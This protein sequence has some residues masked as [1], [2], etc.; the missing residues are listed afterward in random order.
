[1]DRN[2]PVHQL[3]C[4]ADRTE[5]DRALADRFAQVVHLGLLVDDAGGEED[6][7][8]VHR[9]TARGGEESARVR[10][11][12]IDQPARHRHP[13]ALGLGAQTRK[14]LVARDALRKAGVVV[15]EWDVRGAAR[16]VVHQRDA[17]PETREVDRRGESR[18]SRADD[19]AIDLALHSGSF[20]AR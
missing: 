2:P 7:A 18:G 15:R 8:R 11:Q 1:M 14:Q 6:L 20:M 12:R 19:E 5:A 3:E 17:A 13:V 4:V 16:A 9:L 10:M